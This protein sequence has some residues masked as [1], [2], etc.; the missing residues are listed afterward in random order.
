MEYLHVGNRQ[1]K[2]F[3]HICKMVF[4]LW[5]KFSEQKNIL[6]QFLEF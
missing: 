6:S 2:Y 1:G 4:E 5:L 3:I